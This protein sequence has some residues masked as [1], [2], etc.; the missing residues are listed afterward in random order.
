MFP[1]NG[2]VLRPNVQTRML[3]GNLLQHCLKA[4]GV[5]DIFRIRVDCTRERL[6]LLARKALPE[7]VRLRGWGWG[8]ALAGSAIII[9]LGLTGGVAGLLSLGGS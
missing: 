3:V 8:A 6:L 2:I 5:L 9:L 7:P 4:S 1:D